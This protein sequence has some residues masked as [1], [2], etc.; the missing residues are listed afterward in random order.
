[1]N[2][3]CLILLISVM[4]LGSPLNLTAGVVEKYLEPAN[5]EVTKKPVSQNY[6]LR[7]AR[8]YGNLPINFIQNRGQVNGKALFYARTQGYTLWITKDGL[9]FDAVKG[10]ITGKKKRDNTKAKNGKRKS[11]TVIRDVSGLFFPGSRKDLEIVMSDISEHKVNYLIGNDPSKWHVNISTSK[12]ILYKN[13]YPNIDLKVYGIERQ[14]E[15]DWIVKPGG[16]PKKIRMEYQSVKDTR[17]DKE[18][19]LVIETEFGELMHRKPV[20]YQN[21]K[22]NK[23]KVKVNFKR[24][25]RNTYE[26]EVNEY[27]SKCELIIDPLVLVYSTYLGGSG[28][29]GSCSTMALHP[30]GAVY[31]T[32]CTE[33]YDFPTLNP[34]STSYSGREDCIVC[35]IAPDGLSLIY[36]TYIGGSAQERGHAIAVDTQGA[37]YV[38][39]FTYSTDFPTWNAF[40]QWNDGDS[41]AY[42]VKLAP[43]GDSF[44]FSTYL[45]GYYFD[46]GKGIAVDDSGYIYVTGLAWGG[47]PLK[48]PISSYHGGGDVF[49][50]KMTA[51]GNALIYSTYLGGNT[52]DSGVSLVLDT[53]GAVYVAGKTRSYNFP[54]QNPIQSQYMGGDDALVL[55]IDASGKQLMF[56]TYLGG[57]NYDSA[58]SICLGQDG[59]IYISG[60][61]ESANFPTKLGIQNSFG[62]VRD[63]FFSKLDP[64]GNTLIYS[65][66][67]GGDGYENSSCVMV[68]KEGE[69]Y[70]RGYTDS[71]NF[72][73]KDNRE[74]IAGG[75]DIFIVKINSAGNDL[76]FSNFL[77][78]SDDDICHISAIALGPL[79]EVYVAGNTYSVDFPTKNPFQAQNAGG[80]DFF[81]AKMVSDDSPTVKITAPENNAA[82]SGAVDIQVE[83]GDDV[84]IENV[85]FY[86]DGQLKHTDHDAP[87][88]YVWETHNYAN[89]SHQIQVN[90]VDT[91]GQQASDEI[92]VNVQNLVLFLQVSRHEDR[93]WI[94]KKE[95]AK[96]DIA[97]ENPGDIYVDKYKVYRKEPEGEYT[98]IKEIKSIEI[99]GSM[100]T[101]YDLDLK[102]HKTYTYRVIAVNENGE[103][104]G[105][106]SDKTNSREVSQKKRNIFTSIK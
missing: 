12:L 66:Y 57:S 100:H 35:K 74:K 36:S 2:K 75:K 77:G 34:I 79:G 38:T 86:I 17:I 92:K 52:Y 6:N 21:V 54:L 55:K 39:G 40:Q 45:G 7:L 50:T 72:P 10:G 90:A 42:V 63:A 26:F 78:G 105:I 46:S 14:I 19:N 51:N 11:T 58:Y 13:I 1:M 9:I 106:S 95:Y 87:Y 88:Q 80:S 71:L 59:S 69:I 76:I 82:V 102:K 73:V 61:T 32:G 84:G 65:S 104:V 20:S 56:S 48:N 64:T 8:D 30:D 5:S 68:N 99:Q 103:I 85:N 101:C 67:L 83:A 60:S 37:A 16:D 15:Y 3:L 91:S 18:G 62:G 81:I 41:D 96:I 22:G 47:F 4:V 24:I 53:Q 98:L 31:L 70:L 44:V 97:I 33:S 49:I 23:V 29:D 27:N 94:I 93:A 25:R 43:S 89:V 28:V